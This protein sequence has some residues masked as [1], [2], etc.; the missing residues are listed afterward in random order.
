MN[1]SMDEG[2]FSG[3]RGTAAGESAFPAT[4]WTY[5]LAA[6]KQRDGERKEALSALCEGYWYP[7]YAFIRRKGHGADAAGDL[8]QEFFLLLLTG[9]LLERADREK[10]RFRA[11]LLHAVKYFLADEFDRAMA[12]KRGGD[13]IRF[14]LD[15]AEKAYQREPAHDV[16]PDRLFERR[17]AR[18]LLDRVVNVLREEFVRHGRLEHFQ[19]L[20]VY[21]MGQAE[22]PY[23]ELAKKLEM[24]ESALKSG[25]HRFRKRYR[26]LLRAEVASTVSSPEEVDA[27]LRFLLVALSRKGAE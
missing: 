15:D 7:V 12:I 24:S 2:T 19:H 16:T 21:L 5:V 13:A 25:I 6:G 17:W 23:A 27:E 18:A 8:T 14:S 26:D 22:V 20:K 11:F 9:T 1:N 3:T 4:R 10:G